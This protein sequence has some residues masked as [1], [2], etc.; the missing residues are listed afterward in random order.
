MRPIGFSTGALA[1]GDALTGIHL[2]R[3]YGVSAVEVSALRIGELGSIL[4]S[5][6]AIENE[7]ENID[8]VSFHAPSAINSDD[9]R[10]TT[11]ALA[12]A[13][14]N[15]WPIVVHPDAIRDFE[16]WKA[17]G[18]RLCIENM[19]QRKRRGRTVREL[20]DIFRTLPEARFCFDMGHCHQL[21]PTMVEAIL[22]LREFADRLTLI[23]V[24]Q[25]N[26]QSR[27]VP[28]G[29]ATFQALRYV[30]EFI[31]ADCPVIIESVVE[32]ADIARE[33]A[34]VRVCFEAGEPAAFA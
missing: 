12:E 21:D 13:V 10:A 28:L 3:C 16:S 29:F 23:H 22:L 25:L 11:V 17:L 2:Q 7:L 33:L 1:K 9:E 30:M 18:T 26:S 15:E 19:D 24:S 20:T 6:S 5:I 32:G 8:F 14:P 4:S 34:K 31:P 27:H